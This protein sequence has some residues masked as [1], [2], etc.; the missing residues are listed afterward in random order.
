MQS[1]ILAINTSYTR[2]G[3][4]FTAKSIQN[5]NSDRDILCEN[6]YICND[7][8]I[9]FP[10]FF[11][12]RYLNILFYRLF[13]ISGIFN[14]YF[15]LKL[16]KSLSQYKIVHLH[17]IH[18]YYIPFYIIKRIANDKKL[19]ITMHDYHYA[20]GGKAYVIPNQ[21][22]P[23][24]LIDR[25][26][27]RKL[28]YY[29]FINSKNPVIIV[30]SKLMMY[31]LNDM[32][33]KYHNIKVIYNGIFDLNKTYHIPKKVDNII[34]FCFI[35]NKINEGIKGFDTLLKAIKY[36]NLTNIEIYI[37]G[38]GKIKSSDPRIKNLGPVKNENI[39]EIISCFDALISTSLDET[40]GRTVIEARGLGL[41]VICTNIPIYHE[42]LINDALFFDV[43]NFKELSVLMNFF[44]NNLPTYESRVSKSS[45]IRHRFSIQKM[46]EEYSKVYKD[47]LN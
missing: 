19:V 12:R 46:N 43:N 4:G 23:L 15:Y 38:N 20:T 44:C 33:F 17:N 25:S 14:I 40:F 41:Q 22:Y 29:N 18:G 30:P 2:G 7:I 10:L 42:T 39:Y 9:S 27:L 11:L 21:K 32:G 16:L 13:G 26:K 37:I 34:R 36:I 31:K 24:E 28:M 35:A 8:K 45:E 1:K 6:Y 3:A 47:I 5:N